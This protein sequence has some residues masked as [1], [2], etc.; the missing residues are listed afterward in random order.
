MTNLGIEI[1]TSSIN[2]INMLFWRSTG[3]P[4][5]MYITDSEGNPIQDSNGDG[6]EY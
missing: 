6:I 4:V 1:T 5:G 3:T 2:W